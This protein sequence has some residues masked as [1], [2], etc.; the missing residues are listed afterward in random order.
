MFSLEV[1][2]IVIVR[3]FTLREM[4]K[5]ILKINILKK[6]KKMEKKNCLFPHLLLRKQCP[7]HLLFLRKSGKAVHTVKKWICVRCPEVVWK[8]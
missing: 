8:F 4:Q 7:W 2:D 5:V 1:G 3:L 6:K